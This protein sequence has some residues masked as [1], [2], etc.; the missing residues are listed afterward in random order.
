MEH[1]KCSKGEAEAFLE[2]NE[3]KLID[4]LAAWIRH[5][6]FSASTDYDT[7]YCR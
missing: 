7:V 4:A 1:T 2:N 5:A 6:P 3:G